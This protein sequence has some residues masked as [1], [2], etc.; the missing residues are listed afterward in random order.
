[1]ISLKPKGKENQDNDIIK[2]LYKQIKDGC[3]RKI[4]YNIYCHHNLIC[5]KSKQK[6]C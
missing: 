3:P 2:S 1:M 4:C 5:S 6:Y